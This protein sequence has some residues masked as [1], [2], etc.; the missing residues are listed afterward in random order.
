[1]LLL[2][3]VTDV[4]KISLATDQVRPSKT[5]E[6]WKIG[7]L[8]TVAVVLGVLMVAEA[9]VVLWI[10]WSRCGLATNPDALYTYSFL[11][12]LYFAA[13][14]IV[15]ARERRWFW[16]SRPSRAVVMAVMA[17]V[18]VGT[19]LTRVGLPELKPLPWMQTLAIFAGAMGLCLLLNDAVKVA[20][21]RWRAPAA[22]GLIRVNPG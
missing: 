5:P 11:T 10:G 18:L 17:E 21:I 16:A 19:L 3:F 8:L 7:P 13:A 22:A 2:V 14:S 1:M 4:A 12:L 15:S 20:M 6:T 9:L